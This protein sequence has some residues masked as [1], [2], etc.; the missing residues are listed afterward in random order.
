MAKKMKPASA[1]S[2]PEDSG[3]SALKQLLYTLFVSIP[4]LLIMAECASIINRD[5]NA[6]NKNF[7]AQDKAFSNVDPLD[8][9][10]EVKC[11]D[12]DY[13]TDRVQFKQCA[14]RHCARYF[15]DMVINE[16]EAEFLLKIAKK[17]LSYGEASG[18]AS[19]FDLYN[20]VVSHKKSFI[21]VKDKLKLTSSEIDGFNNVVNKIIDTIKSKFGV[22]N[23][24]LTK[25]VFF[26]QMTSK[27]AETLHDEYWHSHIDKDQYEGFHYTTLVYLNSHQHDYYGGRFYW[28]NKKDNTTLSF[29]PRKARLSVFSSGSENRHH[30]EIVKSGVRY[31]V[32]IPFTCNEKLAIKIE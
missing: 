1:K 12:N 23:V 4:I 15:T 5:Y 29:E 3:D 16:N 10:E 19:V 31:A 32:T 30:V 20:K 26:S 8:Y 2:M 18:G 11:G 9:Y 24:Y 14:P 13:K 27:K 7:W 6:R 22:T 28:T 21:S 25:P 17:G